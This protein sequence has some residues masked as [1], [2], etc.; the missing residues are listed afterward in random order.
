MKLL[1][2]LSIL[3][4][5]ALSNTSFSQT[6]F[7]VAE[8][9][10]YPEFTQREKEQFEHLAVEAKETEEGIE[11]AFL[12]GQESNNKYINTYEYQKKENGEKIYTERS[13]DGHVI[14]MI[15]YKKNLF[16]KDQIVMQ[17]FS[18]NGFLMGSFIFEE[19]R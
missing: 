7:E 11:L 19:A 2:L 6:R 13:E 17:Q 4:F 14:V 12:S 15:S 16:S 10:A 8:M 1:Q 3:F 5:L 9:S 18:N